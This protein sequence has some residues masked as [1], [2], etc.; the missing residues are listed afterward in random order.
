LFQVPAGLLTFPSTAR[1][2]AEPL[3]VVLVISAWN[4]PFRKLAKAI[5]LLKSTHNKHMFDSQKKKHVLIK[6]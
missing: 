3:G 5:Q 6:R 1:V 4:Y 2:T